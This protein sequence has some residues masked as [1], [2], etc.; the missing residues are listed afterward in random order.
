MYKIMPSA[1]IFT[2]I[3]LNTMQQGIQSLHV[4][5]EFIANYGEDP[6]TKEW[7]DILDWAQNHK[8]VRIVSAGGSPD[9][10]EHMMDTRELA[11]KYALPYTSFREPDCYDSITAFGIIVTPEVVHEI[12]AT[13]Q[14]IY[15]NSSIAPAKKQE[16]YDDFPLVQHLM[17]FP[18]A[19]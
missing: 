14:E 1:Y 12:E 4:V 8:V 17:K 10:D 3:Y 5:G 9:F 15:D 7:E 11:K 6:C 18:S 16:M 19:R 13:R 2:H